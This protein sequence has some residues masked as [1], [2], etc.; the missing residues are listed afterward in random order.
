MWTRSFFSRFAIGTSRAE[1]RP[2]ASLRFGR[3]REQCANSVLD[4]FAVFRRALTPEEIAQLAGGAA[5]LRAGA[6]T[7]ALA[8]GPRS[9]FY[10]D[11]T[12]AQFEVKIAGAGLPNTPVTVDWALDDLVVSTSQVTLEQ[13]RG[14]AVLD[15]SPARLKT[16]DYVVRVAV[17]RAD[18]S[19]IAYREFPVQVV[20]PC[21]AT[22]S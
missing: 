20:P 17:S 8:A 14:T 16:G 22:I 4:E 19:P 21:G 18:G 1:H 7:A 6:A 12:A 11:E 5:E 3:G 9:V 10:R 15:F 13:G 2:G